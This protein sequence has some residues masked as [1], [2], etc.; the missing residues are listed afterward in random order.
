M[1]ALLMEPKGVQK[2]ESKGVQPAL[3]VELV[4][5]QARSPAAPPVQASPH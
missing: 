3:K 1:L 5:A 2:A 4:W